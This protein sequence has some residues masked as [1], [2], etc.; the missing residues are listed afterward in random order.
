MKFFILTSNR[1]GSTMFKYMVSHMFEDGNE[2]KYVGE[3]GCAP[4]GLTIAKKFGLESHITGSRGGDLLFDKQIYPFLA[5]DKLPPHDYVKTMYFSFYHPNNKV[6]WNRIDVRDMNFIHL[7]RKNDFRQVIS[8]LSAKKTNVWHMDEDADL[9]NVLVSFDRKEVLSGI[10]FIR[11]LKLQ[12]I[13]KLKT[14]NK[15]M[16]VFYE[17]IAE[18][19][20]SD[21]FCKRLENFRDMKIKNSDARPPWAP[22]SSRVDIDNYDGL[23]DLDNEYPYENYL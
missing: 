16:S 9:A 5:Y 19:P 21:D 3:L 8:L 4:A 7:I 22:T 1:T 18:F 15:V 14:A 20:W 11:N 10:N 12:W 17:D 13:E 2:D 6:R 23:K